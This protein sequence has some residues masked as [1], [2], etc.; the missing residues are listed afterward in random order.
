[1]KITKNK[2]REIIKESVEDE[3][4]ERLIDL[5]KNGGENLRQAIELA[6]Y[7]GMEDFLHR[8]DLKKVK[9]LICLGLICRWPD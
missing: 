8:A 9:M 1:M 6:G 2:L 3:H 7:L 5:F 4:K